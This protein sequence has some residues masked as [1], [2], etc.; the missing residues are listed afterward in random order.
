MNAI[1]IGTVIVFV[2]IWLA[3][4]VCWFVSAYHI[5]LWWVDGFKGRRGNHGTQA[6]KAAGIFIAGALLAMA[7]GLIG[8]WLGN[9][10]N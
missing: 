8:V 6:L 7:V 4:V 9:W 10:P 3:C 5:V 2:I 1:G